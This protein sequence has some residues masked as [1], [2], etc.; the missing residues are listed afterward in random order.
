MPGKSKYIDIH[1]HLNFAAF[2]AD[3]EET[4]RRAREAGVAMITVA[5]H[6]DTAAKALD[7]AD[8]HDAMFA[9]VGLHPIHTSASHHDVQELGEGGKE[10][11]SRGEVPDM[12]AYRA[13][14]RHPKTVAIGECGLDYY[15]M[16]AQ[17]VA[18][19][20]RAFESMIDLA[21]EVNKPL[22]LHIRNGSGASAY[23]DAFQ[24][25][26]DRAKVRGN[27]HFFAGTIEE[28]KPFLDLGYTFSFT[29][30]VTFARTYDEVVAYLPLDR[31]MSETDC[32]FVSPKPYRGRR[33]EPAYVI[34]VVR[35]IADIRKQEE[36]A[37]AAQI[38]ENARTLFGFDI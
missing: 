5:T 24:I 16:D 34:E 22:M 18:L 9:A 25:L 33:N 38:M 7:L 21:N 19:Q 31:I 14:A 27:L 35:A 13:L 20:R 36:P 28:A 30:V 1:G 15:R 17:S 12:N 10:F 2:D 8:K 4:I 3:R 23:N 6:Y 37:V 11:T 26:K 29:G 32:P